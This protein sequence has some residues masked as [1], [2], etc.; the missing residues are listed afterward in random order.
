MPESRGELERILESLELFCA[1]DHL[2]R[3]AEA[4][5]E[6]RFH[7]TAEQARATTRTERPSLGR[8]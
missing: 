7:L 6:A 2:P 8:R 1:A 5:G 4:L 3:V